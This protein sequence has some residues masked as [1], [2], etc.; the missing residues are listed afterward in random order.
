M[1]RRAA[2]AAVE[3]WL[4]ANPEL[5]SAQLGDGDYQVILSGD[6]RLSIPVLI[7][8]GERLCTLSS[9]LLRGPRRG[10]A[11]LHRLLLRKNLHLA[12]TRLCLD[13]DDDVVLLARLPLETVT[14]EELDAVFGEILSAGESSFEALV[15][16]GYPGVFPPLR[17]VVR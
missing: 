5:P 3:E 10:A 6:V 16:V 11:D 2:I 14:A 1:T 9:F 17:P 8:A 12:R 15:H 7:H 4:A 13:A